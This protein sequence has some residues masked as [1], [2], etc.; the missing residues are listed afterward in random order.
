MRELVFVFGFGLLLVALKMCH[1]IE[2]RW[3]LV[4]CPI[5]LLL[6][7]TSGYGFAALTAQCHW[8]L[9]ALAVTG[10]IVAIM[11]LLDVSNHTD[12]QNKRSEQC[13]EQN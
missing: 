6:A 10:L 2:W 3:D 13:S 5:W 11:Q 1:V 7:S 4:T 9:R 8:L 12:P